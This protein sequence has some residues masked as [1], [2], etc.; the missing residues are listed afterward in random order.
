MSAE[1][2]VNIQCL[3]GEGPYYDEQ[4]AALYWVD[5][6]DKKVYCYTIENEELHTKEFDQH[7]GCLAPRENG[8]FILG[9]EKGVYS[10]DWQTDTLA[11]IAEP[12]PHLPENRFNDGKCDPMGRFFV[13][14]MDHKEKQTTGSLYM[15]ADDHNVH[16][17]IDQVAISNG[18][19]WSP[20]HTSFYFIDSPTKQVMTYSY[21]K[22]TGHIHSPSVAV[23]FPEGVGVPDGMTMDEEGMLW[24]AHFGGARVSRWNPIS[25]ELLNEYPIPAQNVTS[26][27]FGGPERK[28]LF[29]TTAS[30]KTNDNTLKKHPYSGAVFR[31]RTSVRG[32]KTSLFKG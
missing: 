7:V 28:D 9:M 27:T 22:E 18:L 24:I 14:S 4:N 32:L 3:L 31:I 5:I 26:C 11:H 21:N 1:V 8:G 13:G 29:I 16:P 23:T 2:F 12:E 17:M 20:D 15:V 25:G 10:Y 19:A 6:L 30:A